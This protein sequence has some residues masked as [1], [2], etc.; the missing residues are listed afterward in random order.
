MEPSVAVSQTVVVA[1]KLT[2]Q[3]GDV[4]LV[5]VR[6]GG[7]SFESL[8]RV[9]GLPGDT[10][11]CPERPDGTCDAVVVSG[12]PLLEPWLTGRTD[13]FPAVRVGPRR[14]VPARRQSDVAA[15][16][17]LRGPQRLDAVQGVVVARIAPDGR[18]ERLP[19]TPPHRLP[20]GGETVDPAGPVPPAEV[21]GPAP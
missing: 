21:G 20:D 1:K 2:A 15:D 7:V 18:R 5:E 8:S 16:S 3:R 9:V 13:P 4:V 19:G 14:G 10:V 12:R 17:R 6:D 11:S